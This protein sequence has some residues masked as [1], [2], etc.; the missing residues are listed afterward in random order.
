VN[1]TKQ[2]RRLFYKGL[3]AGN[4]PAPVEVKLEEECLVALIASRKC[5]E[6]GFKFLRAGDF[7][8]QERKAKFRGW[9]KA[10]LKHKLDVPT[11]ECSAE[12]TELC[13][14]LRSLNVRR[15]IRTLSWRYVGAAYQGPVA[16]WL[17]LVERT[18]GELKRRLG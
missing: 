6:Y 10:W 7:T 14:Q 8:K 9:R 12:F 13:R 16:D 1:P 4:P 11:G 3:L 18:H 2:Q 15:W 5:A 17:E